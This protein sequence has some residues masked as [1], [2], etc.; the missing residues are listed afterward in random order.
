MFTG[1]IEKTSKV[2]SLARRS[3]GLIVGINTPAGFALK[4]GDSININ[5]VCSTVTSLGKITEFFYMPET[6]S[7]TYFAN[8]KVGQTVNMERS[9]KVS[10][11]LDGHIVLGHVDTVGKV[12]SIKPAGGSKIL[13]VSLTKSTPLLAPKGSVSL[14]GISLT[15]VNV[16]KKSFTAHVIPYTLQH[17]NLGAK[18]PGDPVN[19]EFDVL[20][21]YINQIVKK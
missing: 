7:K 8:L 12:K 6:L 9:L 20:A 13:E 16:S 11:R 5:G 4:K 14:E 2:A 21:K 18:K 19:V 15:T 10:A 17:T 1:I 3:G